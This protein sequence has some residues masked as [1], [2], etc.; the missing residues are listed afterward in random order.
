MT[1][2]KSKDHSPVWWLAFIL[3]GAWWFYLPSLHFGLIWDDPLWYRQGAGQTVI[4]VF[5]QLKTYQYYRPLAILLNHQLVTPGGVVL[6]WTA[7]LIQVFAFLLGLSLTW[8]VARGLAFRRLHSGLTVLLVAACPLAFQAVAW[9]APIQPI[10]TLLVLL[11]LRAYSRFTDG[12]RPLWLAL[13]LV[14]Y[15]AGL[16]FQESAV[17]FSAVFVWLE[18][19]ARRRSPSRGPS[20]WP[21][22]HVA[23]A[24]GYLI[25]WLNLPRLSGVT[26]VGSQTRV[27]AYLFQAV[28]YPMAPFFNSVG[29]QWPAAAWVVLFGLGILGL[30]A[31]SYLGGLR[32]STLV[33]LG[34][35][36]LG[37]LPVWAGLSYDYVQIGSRLIYPALLGIAGLWAGAL[38][39]IY[40]WGALGRWLAS[41]LALGLVLQSISIGSQFRRMYVVGTG[42]LEQAIQVAARTPN[43][44]I[45]FVNFP[46]RF[47]PVR[48]PYPLGYWGITLAPPVVE[49]KDFA[50]STRGRGAQTHTLVLPWVGPGTR[51]DWPY[52]VDMRGVVAPPQDLL[53][54]TEWADVTYLTEYLSDGSLRLVLAGRVDAVRSQTPLAEFGGRVSLAEVEIVAQGPILVTIRLVWQVRR[55]LAPADTVFLH[56]FDADGNFVR[57]MDGDGLGGILPLS[58]WKPG[59]NITD[60]RRFDI[61]GLPAGRYRLGFGIYDRDSGQRYPALGPGSGRFPEDEALLLSLEVQ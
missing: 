13:S 33:T 34:W 23:L 19:R 42:H 32:Q 25:I 21:T 44:R 9:Q 7:H 49:I 48:S 47:E 40:G 59:V 27:L 3:L 35:A 11:A 54:W 30:A 61:S 39:V 41:A 52:R 46:D 15:G 53:R 2:Q 4:Q 17:P 16:I 58:L 28:M 18:Y 5:F 56:L 43:R 31:L 57:G 29:K 45:L 24:A 51:D 26:G 8:A 55:A 36:L 37:L 10:V 1:T 38:V 12:R 50:L 60:F 20:F 14:A 22:A 6:A